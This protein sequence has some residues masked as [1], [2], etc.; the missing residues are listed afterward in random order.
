M[1]NDLVPLVIV[2]AVLLF[3]VLVLLYMKRMSVRPVPRR[4]RH[5]G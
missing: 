1:P 5:K 4:R 3:G 2:L